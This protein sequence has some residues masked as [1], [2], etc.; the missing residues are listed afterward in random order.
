[1]DLALIILA[2]LLV[3]F[4]IMLFNKTN[5]L[6]DINYDLEKEI[7]ELKR[8][9]CQEVHNNTVLLNKNR[10]LKGFMEEIKDI[11]SSSKTLPEKEDKLKE[12]LFLAQKSNSV[13]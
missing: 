1:M 9:R 10:E 3:G 6:S 12:L 4:A 8:L 11:V 7:E 13:K 2:I 5:E